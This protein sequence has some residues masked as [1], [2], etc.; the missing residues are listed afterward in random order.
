MISERKKYIAKI[1][2]KKSSVYKIMKSNLEFSISVIGEHFHI[3]K[4]KLL[5][6]KKKFSVDKYIERLFPFLD[7][8]FTIEDMQEAIK[9]YS[10]DVGIKISDPIFLD[11]IN[12]VGAKI[13]L[14]IEQE[15]ALENDRP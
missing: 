2:L 8:Q 10:S 13:E 12:G 5:E 14:E 7:K 6:I 9:F 15:I 11:K 1:L 4:D 3:P